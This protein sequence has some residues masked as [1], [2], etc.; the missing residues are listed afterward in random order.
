ML[1]YTI[2]SFRY[3]VHSFPG[4]DIQREKYKFLTRIGI[5]YNES[6]DESAKTASRHF[7][8][9]NISIPIEDFKRYTQHN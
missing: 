4:F 7:S 2:F 6:A 5:V 8:F 9:R 1:T 3:L